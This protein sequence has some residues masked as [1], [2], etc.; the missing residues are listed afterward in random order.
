TYIDD[1]FTPPN[2]FDILS[3]SALSNRYEYLKFIVNCRYF[4]IDNLIGLYD[5][6]NISRWL[7]YINS[8][9]SLH[10]LHEWYKPRIPAKYKSLINTLVLQVGPVTLET[11]NNIDFTTINKNIVSLL[12]M[13]SGKISGVYELLIQEINNNNIIKIL[14]ENLPFFDDID[15]FFFTEF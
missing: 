10:F 5:R 7:F 4:N 2:I 9:N 8:D 6:S 1:D 3:F 11:F 13:R 15:L 12:F 14:E